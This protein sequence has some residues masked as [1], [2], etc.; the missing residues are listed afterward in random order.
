MIS[1][2]A[3]GCCLPGHTTT[4]GTKHSYWALKVVFGLNHTL[5]GRRQVAP[6]DSRRS[7]NVARFLFII[8]IIKLNDKE[9]GTP[10][11]AEHFERRAQQLP[12]CAT[13][14]FQHQVLRVKVWG[15]APAVCKIFFLQTA[16]TATALPAGAISGHGSDILNAAD[17]HAGTGEGAERSLG[18]RAGGLGLDTS[19]GTD[20]DVEGSDA[21][22]LEADSHILRGKHSSVGRRLVTIGLHLHAAGDAHQGLT[23]GQ[24]G[25]VHEG[26]VEGGEDASD[27]ENILTILLLR[28]QGHNGDFFHFL[29]GHCSAA[30]T[31]VAR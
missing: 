16:T 1:E 5:S 7:K 17:L 14:H 11:S 12:S 24:I 22:L 18:T 31:N 2:S 26:V 10:G 21:E 13:E 29:G 28:S 6:R 8:A 23:A 27:G 4:H 20:L 19:G 15:G 3:S 25:N 30:H 9:D